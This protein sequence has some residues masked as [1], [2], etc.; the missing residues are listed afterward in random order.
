MSNQTSNNP[1]PISE[2]ILA[3]I[4]HIAAIFT[5]IIGPIVGY[6]ALKDRSEFLRH[7]TVQAL[8]FSLTLLI[9]YIG[10][11]ISLVGLLVI[12]AVPIVS[13]IMRVLSALKAANGEY[14]KNPLAIQFIK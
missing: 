5:E 13:V 7:H 12:W 1:A 2:P 3:L 4:V 11:A 6:V 9:A 10:L 14:Y 8:N